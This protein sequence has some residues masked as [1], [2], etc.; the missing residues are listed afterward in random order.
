MWLLED[1]SDATRLAF[2]VTDKF[3][4]PRPFVLGEVAFQIQGPE[5]SQMITPFNWRRAEML[6][7]I[8]IKTTG[9]GSG[10]IR[11]QAS[12][13]ELGNRSVDINVRTVRDGEIT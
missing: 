13:S 10:R 4:A 3:G 6:A 2:E 1:G 9:G 11:T 8:W 12:H 5:S 7:Q